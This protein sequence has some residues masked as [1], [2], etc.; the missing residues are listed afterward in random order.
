MPYITAATINQIVHATK[1]GP[2]NLNPRDSLL[3]LR[4]AYEKKKYI[5]H[6]SNT[7]TISESRHK[8]SS[9]HENK[10]NVE[11]ELN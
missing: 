9:G 10:P 7:I 3:E 8:V 5:Q 11:Q 2:A 4:A 6:E 1:P